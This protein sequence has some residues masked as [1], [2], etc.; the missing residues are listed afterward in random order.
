MEQSH[1]TSIIVVMTVLCMTLVVEGVSWLAVYRTDD[2]KRASARIVELNEKV[3]KEKE[4]IVSID[5]RKVHEKKI[6]R[7]EEDL[8]SANEAVNKLKLRVTIFV[9]LCYAAAYYYLNNFVFGKTA[10]ARVPFEPVS[11]FKGFVSR[12]LNSNDLQ[13]VG[14]GFLYAISSTAIKSNMTKLLGHA[15]PRSSYSAW[16]EHVKRTEKYVNN[17][18]TN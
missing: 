14:F 7:M 13:E 10:L 1:I 15:P 3:A 4:L 5:R 8:K 2:F 18:T 12:G 6:A 9:S 16:E 11:F 17:F